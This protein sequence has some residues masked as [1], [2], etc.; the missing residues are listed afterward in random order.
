MRK[1]LVKIIPGHDGEYGIIKLFDGE[2]E[3]AAGP[4]LSLF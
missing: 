3:K 2:E 1:G 4:Q